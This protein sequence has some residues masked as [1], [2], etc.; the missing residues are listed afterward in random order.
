VATAHWLGPWERQRDRWARRW[1]TG[2]LSLPRWRDPW[3]S[4]MGGGNEPGT[5]RGRA[6]VRACIALHDR[7]KRGA[8]RRLLEQPCKQDA[9]VVA[10]SDTITRERTGRAYRE[11]CPRDPPAAVSADAPPPIPLAPQVTH[12]TP[13]PEP[14]KAHLLADFFLLPLPPSSSHVFGTQASLAPASRVSTRWNRPPVS[15]P[16]R[17]SRT[18]TLT[19]HFVPLQ[20]I[21]RLPPRGRRNK[22]LPVHC[23]DKKR[24]RSR[25]RRTRALGEIER[26][27][28]SSGSPAGSPTHAPV[29][30]RARLALDLKWRRWGDGGRWSLR[31]RC[32]SARDGWSPTRRVSLLTSSDTYALC[33]AVQIASLC[34]LKI[35][36]AYL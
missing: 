20:K 7:V 13:P 11:P 6:A 9:A 30:S 26:R 1:P 2:H 21:R 34:V 31:S 19:E 3:G 22:K 5:G 23:R 27:P 29:S 33:C 25:G 35:C 16:S 28:C 36:T 17:S 14:E 32:W 10:R 8:A 4:E 12:P 24:E 18:N 15:I